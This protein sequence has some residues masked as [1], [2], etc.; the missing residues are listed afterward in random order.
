MMAEQNES[1]SNLYTHTC[2]DTR[3]HT[4][5]TP[6]RMLQEE[7]A[8]GPASIH[9]TGSWTHIAM[10]EERDGDGGGEGKKDRGLEQDKGG[11]E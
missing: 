1:L 10:R 9:W 6:I 7:V 2:M 11:R 8:M 4:L 3:K 5:P